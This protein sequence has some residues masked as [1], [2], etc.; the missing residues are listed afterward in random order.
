M[1]PLLDE[2]ATAR[3]PVWDKR[4]GPRSEKM[5]LRRTVLEIFDSSIFGRVL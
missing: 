2:A 1:K 4:C 5:Y 3:R